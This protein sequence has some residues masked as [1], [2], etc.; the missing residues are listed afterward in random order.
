M[1]KVKVFLL[2][3]L[4]VFF[5][6]CK[7]KVTIEHLRKFAA[8]ETFPTDIFLDTVSNKKALI[9]VAHDDDDCAMSGTIAKLTKYGWIIK[10]LSLQS[11]ILLTMGRNPA[12]IIC[13]GNEI[14][15]KDGYYRIGL[16]TMKNPYLPIPYKKIKEQFLTDKVTN[17]IIKKVNDFKPSVIFTLDNEKGG[18]GHPEHIFIS[19]LV[20]DLFEENK[21]HIDKIYQS[22]YTDH[23]EKEIVDKWLGDRLKKWGYPNSSAIANEIYGISGMP[24]PTVQVN[25][26]EVAEI[27]MKYLRAY[28]EDVRKNLRKFIP[29]Y[30][31]FDAKTYFGIFDREFFRVIEKINH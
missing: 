14:I 2:A 28:E 8:T 22:V 6:F 15:L 31:E 10:Q 23:M 17:E 21:I 26:T 19:Q 24:E 12:Q 18:Y 1:K 13:Q 5:Q 9:I 20:K 30:E 16:D 4:V 3:I 27:K 11:H 29:Y 7:D 25:I